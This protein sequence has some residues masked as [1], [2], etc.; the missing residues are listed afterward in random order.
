MKG[1]TRSLD[2]SL[3]G[4]HKGAYAF[5][6]LKLSQRARS[7]HI[8]FPSNREYAQICKGISTRGSYRVPRVKSC[9]ICPRFIHK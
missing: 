8:R 7:V 9:V 4:F 2:Y 3:Y 1:D 5:A 6:G